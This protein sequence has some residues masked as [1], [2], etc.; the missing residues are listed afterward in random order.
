MRPELDAKGV[1]LLLVSIGT[2]ERGLE[3][4]AKT[5][6]PAERLLA[7]GDSR[8]YEALSM[9][10]GL[11]ETFFSPEVRYAIEFLRTMFFYQCEE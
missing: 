10:K 1:Q 6:F 2:K 8:V 4:V 7:D 5:G 11:K 9:K 3:F